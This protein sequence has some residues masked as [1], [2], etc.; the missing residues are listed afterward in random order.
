VLVS[1]LRDHAY[2][3]MT[4]PIGTAAMFD[5]HTLLA[6]NASLPVG[7]LAID[8]GEVLFR[9]SCSAAGFTSASAELALRHAAQIRAHVPRSQI[10]LDAFSAAL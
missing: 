3:T 6:F 7:A 9:F 1:N 5:P 8:D 10:V 4:V 2:A